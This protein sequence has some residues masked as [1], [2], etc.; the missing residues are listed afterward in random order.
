MLEILIPLII[1]F[2]IIKFRF[3]GK[4][5][6]NDT[7]FLYETL[8]SLTFLGSVIGLYL[9]KLQY[10]IIDHIFNEASI[11]FGLTSSLLLFLSYRTQFR[12][13]FF[14]IDLSLWLFVLIIKGGYCFGFAACAPY[15]SIILFDIASTLLR[16]LIL[17]KLIFEMKLISIFF[18]T[19]I[20][21]TGKA[22][23]LKYPLMERMFYWW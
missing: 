11:I 14:I 2:L 7:R 20:L 4:L 17:R 10:D 21:I 3:N 5:L 22:I 12:K 1:C 8:I 16:L 13:T 19:A 18:I 23:F 6:L 15:P 9:N